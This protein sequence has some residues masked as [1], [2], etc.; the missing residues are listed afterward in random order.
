MRSAPSQGL[1][2]SC[3]DSKTFNPSLGGA[4]S[5]LRQAGELFENYNADLLYFERGVIFLDTL[6][7]FLLLYLFII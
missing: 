6:L 2:S 7:L 4:Y 1:S 5:G 3:K